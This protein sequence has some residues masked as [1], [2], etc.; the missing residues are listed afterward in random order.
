MIFVEVIILMGS[1]LITIILHKKRL[2]I[3]LKDGG[4]TRIKAFGG[5]RMQIHLTSNLHISNNNNFLQLMTG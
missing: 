1:V 5:N 3:Y 2:I 4:A